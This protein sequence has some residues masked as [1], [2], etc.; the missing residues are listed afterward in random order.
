MANKAITLKGTNRTR[1]GK[2]TRRPD[3]KSVV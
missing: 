1:L 3:R 2:E